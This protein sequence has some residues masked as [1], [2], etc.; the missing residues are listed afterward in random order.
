MGFEPTSLIWNL[1]LFGP[2]NLQFLLS[3][4]VRE[5]VWVFTISWNQRL[6]ALVLMEK[7]MVNK[8]FCKMYLKYC[9]LKISDDKSIL[10]GDL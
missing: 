9:Y 5:V 6:S 8:S 4:G 1:N 10:Y 3:L 2:S 7:L